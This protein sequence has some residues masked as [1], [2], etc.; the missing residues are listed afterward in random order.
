MR[1]P[2]MT[3]GFVIDDDH[4]EGT[5]ACMRTCP[6]H[7]IRVKDGK[8]RLIPEQCIDCGS[9]LKACPTGAITAAT[10][11]FADLDRFKFKVAVPAPALFTQFARSDTPE[12]VGRSLL[13]LGFD[14]V[15]EYAVDIELINRS[16]RDFVRRWN[17]PF[18][19]IS[20]SCPVVVRLVQVSYPTMV[21]QLIPIDAPREIAGREIKRVYSEKLKIPPEEIAAVYITPCQAKTI[22]IL[23]PAEE[24]KSHLDGSIGISEIYNDILFNIRRLESSKPGADDSAAS[25]KIFRMGYP[26]GEFHNLSESHYLPLTGL[27][28]IINVFDDIEKGKIRNIEFL[29]CHACPGGCIGGNLTVENMYVARAKKLNLIASIPVP[30]KEYLLE[31]ERRYVS[32]DLSLRAPLKPR[33]LED[34]KLDL[35]E[36]VRRK[37]K[38]NELMTALPGLNCGLCG[39]PMCRDHAEDV[40]AGMADLKDC[41]FISKD[42][43]Q[44]LKKYYYR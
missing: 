39:A 6:T 36:R 20:S 13:Q 42:R 43:I 34:G 12:L 38:S 26:E 14:A 2:E 31:V 8:A 24:V 40:A 23:Q 7:A 21:E 15:W 44:N 27:T 4:C 29:E 16:I 28:D 35:H 19:L 18:P 11:T 37:K 1:T 22:S 30:T 17:G 33:A 10:L 25:R 3:H 32:E 9:C 5:M 41:V